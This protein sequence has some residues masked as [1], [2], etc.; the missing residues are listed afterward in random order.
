MPSAYTDRHAQLCSTPHGDSLANSREDLLQPV[1]NETLKDDTTS[2]IAQVCTVTPRPNIT[3]HLPATLSHLTQVRPFCWQFPDV[4]NHLCLIPFPLW[5]P[6]PTMLLLPPLHIMNSYWTFYKQILRYHCG[7]T[8][9]HANRTLILS[10]V[11]E[12]TAEKQW[13]TW[14]SLLQDRCFFNVWGVTEKWMKSWIENEP[15][16][17]V[18]RFNLS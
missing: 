4:Y 6:L 5:L 18:L 14:Q 10:F 2:S 1:K 12:T 15:I 16:F 8:L 17:F 11:Q 13:W 7:K 9:V 3:L